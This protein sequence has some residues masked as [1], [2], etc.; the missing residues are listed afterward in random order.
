MKKQICLIA[1]LALLLT[2]CADNSS[3]GSSDKA[4]S[5]TAAAESA[6]GNTEENDPAI[7][8]EVRYN[9]HIVY[10][11]GKNSDKNKLDE[12]AEVIGERI[13]ICVGGKQDVRKNYDENKFTI[14]FDSDKNLSDF[15][16]EQ[17]AK[18]NKVVFRKG[19][20][21]TDEVVLD[22]DDID[23]V[24]DV[25]DGASENF[26]VNITLSEKGGRVFSEVTSELA[27]TST[28]VSIWIDDECVSSPTVNA[29][30]ADGVLIITGN[31]DAQSTRELA[32][33]M[34]F[35]YLPYDVVVEE[36]AHVSK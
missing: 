17:S 34:N 12:A 9:S 10:S 24:C 1:S 4:A 22:G 20:A 8:P 21:D 19:S 15:L 27:G 16:A 13:N 30:V 6:S 35:P 3:S 29:P 33:R 25:Y 11:M 5:S 26:A 18:P 23:S 32:N 28:P 14:Y 7:D 36:S 2:G 31:F